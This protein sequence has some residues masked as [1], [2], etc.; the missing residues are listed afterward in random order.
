MYSLCIHREI[1]TGRQTL[2]PTDRQIPK[3]LRANLQNFFFSNRTPAKAAQCIPRYSKSP[4][5]TLTDKNRVIHASAAMHYTIKF[6]ASGRHQIEASGFNGASQL[7]PLFG[8]DSSI[9]HREFLIALVVAS[10]VCMQQTMQRREHSKRFQ[11][12]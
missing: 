9:A 4:N 7:E 6:I 3:R 8:G 1:E 2:K 5:P 11:E 12:L 10:C